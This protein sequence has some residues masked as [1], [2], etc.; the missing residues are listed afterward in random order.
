MDKSIETFLGV[1]AVLLLV[2]FGRALL[3][4]EKMGP[5][6]LKLLID[7]RQLAQRELEKITA[8]PRQ[9]AQLSR[10]GLFWN[11]VARHRRLGW[12]MMSVAQ[13]FFGFL[14]LTCAMGAVMFTVII[15]IVVPNSP[16]LLAGIAVVIVLY[17]II[18]RVAYKVFVVARSVR[19]ELVTH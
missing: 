14:A 6:I 9:Q 8:P 11:F 16:A 19:R 12:V 10:N 17:A 1:A 7:L 3:E 4:R 13:I 18:G 2:V 5:E 15:P